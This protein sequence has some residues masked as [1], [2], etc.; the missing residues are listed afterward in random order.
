MSPIYTPEN[1]WHGSVVNDMLIKKNG[2]A[3]EDFVVWETS[4]TGSIGTAAD[5]VI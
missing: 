3:T 1:V 5:H 2:C 4:H